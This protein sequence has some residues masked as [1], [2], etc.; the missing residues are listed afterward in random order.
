M[1]VLAFL[2]LLN[3]PVPESPKPGEDRRLHDAQI[4]TVRVVQNDI[5]T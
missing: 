4:N 3:P 2:I 5:R 1:L